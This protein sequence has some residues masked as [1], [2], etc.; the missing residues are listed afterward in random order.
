[1][2]CRNNSILCVSANE[3]DVDE[4]HTKPEVNPCTPYQEEC[5][6]LVCPYGTEGYVDNNGCNRCQCHDPCRH[7]NCED[8]TQ[9]VIEI[10]QYARAD[11]SQYIAV[12]RP[13]E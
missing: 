12:C 9:C 6:S 11:Q 4:P 8:G 3:V 2:S 5:V 1:M 10:N 7:A 13:C